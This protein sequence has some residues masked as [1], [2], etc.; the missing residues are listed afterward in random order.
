MKSD[1][2]SRWFVRVTAPWEYIE[3]KCKA[4]C[5]MVDYNSSAVGYHIGN[6][7]KKPHAHLA[8]IMN[9]ELQ[10]QSF[11]VRMKK[12]FELKGT[13]YSSKP[14]D[15]C[16]KALSYLYHDKAGKVD[17]GIVLSEDEKKEISD[18]VVVY[19]DIVTTAKAKASNKLTDYVL[20]AIKDSKEIWS[21]KRIYEYMLK[22]I[23]SNKFHSPGQMRMECY[24]DDIILRQSAD[25]LYLEATI[26]SM[27]H[28]FFLRY[29]RC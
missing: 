4:L 21:K 23:A 1:R 15:G 25:P 12:I 8:I 29:D 27:S 20:D 19:A 10:K 11:D 6:K 2:S 17:M 3:Q 5:E 22:A 18:L 16:K 9:T 14:W 7:T 13:D 28:K 24:I 26:D